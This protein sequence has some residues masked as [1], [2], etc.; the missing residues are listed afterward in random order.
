MQTPTKR[1]KQRRRIR[2]QIQKNKKK[3]IMSYHTDYEYLDNMLICGYF[4]INCKSIPLDIKRFAIKY[5]PATI[6]HSKLSIKR[7][8][9][10]SIVD[11]VIHNIY[12]YDIRTDKKTDIIIN[13][14]DSFW[15]KLLKIQQ[16]LLFNK[17]VKQAQHRRYNDGSIT[18]NVTFMD[19]NNKYEILLL[20]IGYLLIETENRIKLKLSNLGLTDHCLYLFCDLIK[21]ICNKCKQS[22]NIQVL[23][24][25]LNKKISDKY[26]HLLL[27]TIEGF[28]KNKIMKTLNLRGTSITNLSIGIIAKYQIKGL[29]ITTID[30][31][32]CN[33]ITL[34]DLERYSLKQINFNNIKRKNKQITPRRFRKKTKK[35]TKR[36]KILRHSCIKQYNYIDNTY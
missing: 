30:I 17:V 9:Y 27:S 12:G 5:I 23:D 28:N 22:L 31:S 32:E 11:N 10:K 18:V 1:R 34:K 6:V 16:R 25:S 3:R 7:D 20:H 15:N 14:N 26:I 2:H 13:L 36:T 21:N 29:K 4:R 35:K 33:K 19:N 8:L 24:L